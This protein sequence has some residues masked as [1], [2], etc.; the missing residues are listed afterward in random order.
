MSYQIEYSQEAH[1]DLRKMPARFRNR[2]RSMIEALSSDPRP[3]RSK[4]LRGLHGLYRLRLGQWRIIY[5]IDD[6]DTQIQIIRIKR[7]T[8]PETYEH[9]GSS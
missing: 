3:M 9:L 8:G 5:L 7:K 4:E 6:E 2:A 1:L